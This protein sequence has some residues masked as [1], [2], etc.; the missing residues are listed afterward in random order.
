MA[1]FGPKIPPANDEDYKEIQG[2]RPE[3]TDKGNLTTYTHNYPG[4]EGMRVT[5]HINH[6][7]V[8]IST[9]RGD[10][11]FP[12]DEVRAFHGEPCEKSSR[13]VGGDGYDRSGE[14]K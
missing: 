8:T 5:S 3:R 7:T 2:G 1:T 13:N 10:R 12:V 4:G 9:S 11:E 6:G 14:R